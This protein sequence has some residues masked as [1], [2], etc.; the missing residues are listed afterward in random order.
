MRVDI[1]QSWA[2]KTNYNISET[3]VVFIVG[4]S[5]VSTS[6]EEAEFNDIVHIDVNESYYGLSLKT[7]A[8]FRYHK[9]FCPQARC[10][11]KVD[12]DVST[13]IAG[14]EQLCKAQKDAPMVTGHCYNYRTRVV[15]RYNSKF[16]LP[17]FIY[18]LEKFPLYCSGAA[19]MFSGYNIVDL[20]LDAVTK[21]P[22]LYSENFRRLSEDVLF[23]GLI[24][25][26]ANVPK[27]NNA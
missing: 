21:S 14:I 10:V 12:S 13:N 18:A 26:L 25:I 5:E 11:L 16:Y 15:R 4:T 20:F 6:D 7:Y 1:R 24:R 19:Y 2:A 9:E 3:Q 23:T 17:R 8:I 22:F 27:Q